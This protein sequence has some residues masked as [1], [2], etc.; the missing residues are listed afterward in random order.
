MFCCVCIYESCAVSV[1][2]LAF[3]FFSA[4]EGHFAVDKMFLS[5]YPENCLPESSSRNDQNLID[6]LEYR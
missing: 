4:M 1:R 6:F 2:G 5:V 3:Y